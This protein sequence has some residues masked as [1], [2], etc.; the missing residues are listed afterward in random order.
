M[1]G[2]VSLNNSFKYLKL[3][4]KISIFILITI[5]LVSSSCTRFLNK[6]AVKHAPYDAIIVPGVPYHGEEWNNA[7]KLRVYWSYLLFKRGMTEHI[8]YSGSAVYTE[9]YEAEIMKLYAIQLGVPEEIILTDTIAEHST[10]NLWYSHKLAHQNGLKKLALA[11]DPFQNAMVSSF[12][13]YHNLNIKSIPVIFADVDSFM[14]AP[15]PKI[16]PSSAIDKNFKSIEE[17]ESKFKQFRG[18]LGLN[19]D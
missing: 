3:K 5:I 18:T 8:I 16:D 17:R 9:Y 10:E 12:K 13:R 6:I 7:M 15:S 2:K 1:K 14:R 4:P 11:T 19:I